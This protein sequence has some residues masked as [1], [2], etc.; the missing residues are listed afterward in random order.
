MWLKRNQSDVYADKMRA[1]NNADEI[2]QASTD[3]V[4]Q[5][6]THERKDDI[7]DFIHGNVQIDVS[8]Q[9]YDADVV[10]GTKKDGSMLLYD[11][12]GMTKKEMQRTAGRQ[13]APHD[14][15][16]ASLSDTSVTQNGT[17][18]NPYDMPN[19]VEYAVA[20]RQFGNV[21][22]QELDV[23]TDGVKEFLRGRPVRDRD[24]P[25]AGAARERRYQRAR[26]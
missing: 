25:G 12:V 2:L 8:G 18:V 6:L 24:Q 16:A 19:D 7:V 23:L 17:G 4:S 21:K 10:V 13:S 5:E 15:R 3:H 11:F 22:A 1:A 20:P 14:I 9:L 26:H